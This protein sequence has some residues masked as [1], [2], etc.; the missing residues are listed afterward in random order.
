MNHEQVQQWIGKTRKSEATISLGIAE[1]MQAS[2]NRKSTFSLGD[3]LPPAWHWLYFHE[4][5]AADDLGIEG[6][7]ALGHFMPPVDFGVGFGAPAAPRRMWAGGRL[8]FLAPLS[9]GDS[10][11]RVSRIHSIAHKEGRS[12]NLVFVTVEH[13]L[14]RKQHGSFS[15]SPAIIEEQDI[16]YRDP[17]QQANNNAAQR[18]T[19][20]AEFSTPYQPDPILL[21]RYSALTFNAHR[22]HY[23]GDFCREVEGYPNLVVHGPLI[24]T[25]LLDLFYHRFPE[26]AISSFSYRSHSPL[27]LPE[28]FSVNG[29]ADGS[30]WAANAA[31]GLAMSATVGYGG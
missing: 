18:P 27:F 6:H 4:A 22:I 8:Q 20:E 28:A 1:R 17:S 11:Q 15:N 25:L 21:F 7:E 13:R 31:G 24:A 19:N 16:V 12:G 29:K 3:S 2:L 30:A 26:K 9:L 14:Y 10:V 23:D 5:V